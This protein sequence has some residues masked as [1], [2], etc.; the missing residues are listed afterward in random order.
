M[1]KT[2]LVCWASHA[3][4][5]DARRC[6]P[7]VD[8]RG[9]SLFL[10]AAISMLF[11]FMGIRNSWNT[12]TYVALKGARQSGERGSHRAVPPRGNLAARLS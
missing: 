7:C 5:R 6:G 3:R 11:L 4:L 12:V 2:G 8:A 9:V 1:L 10:I